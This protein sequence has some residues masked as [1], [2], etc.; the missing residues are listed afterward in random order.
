MRNILVFVFL[1]FNIYLH[2]NEINIYDVF[3]IRFNFDVS[4]NSKTMY[5]DVN[6]EMKTI[7]VKNGYS[8]HYKNNT[9]NMFIYLKVK[10]GVNE[11]DLKK[12][13]GIEKIKTRKNSFGIG[14]IDRIF[15]LK[16]QTIIIQNK[17]VEIRKYI[18]EWGSDISRDILAYKIELF[19]N[20]Y[21][22]NCIIEFYNV[23]PQ[24]D[25]KLPNNFDLYYVEKEIKKGNI[26]AEVY[27]LID[28]SIIN[29]IFSNNIEYLNIKKYRVI[30]DRLRFRESFNSESK[31]IRVL[32][33]NEKV[34]FLEKG[35]EDLINGVKGNW[36]K[37]KT[38]TGE[39]GWCFDG[40]LEEIK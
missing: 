27:K 31:I 13:V 29:I 35:K 17:D 25:V 12:L 2:C 30:I 9:I 38:E 11:E 26:K 23:W 21:F 16:K 36:I 7:I 34:L 19:N 33:K 24:N 5:Y 4:N 18:S 37:V 10:E 1:L 6:Q 39:I 8:F 32:S 40:Y 15:T 14:D 28:D 20:K 3:N 22:N